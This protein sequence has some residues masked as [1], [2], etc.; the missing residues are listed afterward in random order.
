MIEIILTRVLIFISVYL[1]NH[2]LVSR[3]FKTSKRGHYKL[4][5]IM[6]LFVHLPL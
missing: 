3:E 4:Q 2:D 5:E 6:F 1:S